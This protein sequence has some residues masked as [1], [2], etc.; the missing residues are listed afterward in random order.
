MKAEKPLYP[1]VRAEGGFGGGGHA[2]D[3]VFNPQY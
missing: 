3:P 1:A 2:G